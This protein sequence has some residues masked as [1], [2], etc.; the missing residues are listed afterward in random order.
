[1]V[2]IA[3]L[4]G[5][6]KMADASGSVRLWQVQSVGLD[7]HD[8]DYWQSKNLQMAHK[9]ELFSAVGLVECAMMYILMLT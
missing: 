8:L 6:R 7:H 2:D 3:G 5:T 1:M 9:P 4:V